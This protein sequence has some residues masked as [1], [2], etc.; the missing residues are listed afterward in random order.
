MIQKQKALRI[1]ELLE[2]FP[3]CQPDL[4]LLVRF[5]VFTCFSSLYFYLINTAAHLPSPT[6][7]HH[8]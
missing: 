8:H 4:G 3:S 6:H 1:S 2:A 5:L 7:Y